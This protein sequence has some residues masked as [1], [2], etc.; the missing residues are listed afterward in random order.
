MPALLTHVSLT[1]SMMLSI[2]PV[3][4]TYERMNIMQIILSSSEGFDFSSPDGFHPLQ[5]DKIFCKQLC[6]TNI[7]DGSP[8]KQY[9]RALCKH[10]GK[11]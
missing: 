8:D 1:L 7:A 3:L 4:N 10:K 11:R 5:L 2:P 9:K 6:S